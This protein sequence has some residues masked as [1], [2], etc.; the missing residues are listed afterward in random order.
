MKNSYNPYIVAL[1]KGENVN[2]EI[3]FRKKDN[4][5]I[6]NF[7][8][9]LPQT[10]QKI[11]LIFKD[12]ITEVHMGVDQKCLSSPIDKKG[13]K[14]GKPVMLTQKDLIKNLSL[15]END[16]VHFS[17]TQNG[18]VFHHVK[19]IKENG[20][21]YFNNINE[22]KINDLADKGLNAE[23]I[24]FE[25]SENLFEGAKKLV[26]IN[27]YERNP[28]ARSLCLKHWGTKCSVC[29]IVFEKVYGEL[30]K[31]FIHVHHLIPVSQIGKSY[32]IDPISDLR[33]VCPNCHAM[34]HLKNPPMTIEEIKKVINASR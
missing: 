13:S 23:E 17:I 4:N 24:L 7:E 15:E 28:K 10:G 21:I 9:Y 16:K 8:K 25:E 29:E 33:P 26:I 31:G 22:N 30:G 34:I 19:T 11:K 27:A 1:I 20:Q 12:L 3:S 6:K 18:K 5:H 32:Q 14:N 2:S